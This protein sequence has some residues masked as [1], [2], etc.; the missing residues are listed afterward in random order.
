MRDLHDQAKLDDDYQ[1]K[2]IEEF[3]FPA[4]SSWMCY[5]DQVLHAALAGRNA[6]EQTFFLDPENMVDE[7][8][9]PLRQLERLTNRTLV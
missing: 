1:S 9:S 2:G 4:G 5:T 8:K 6:L 7:S 3:A